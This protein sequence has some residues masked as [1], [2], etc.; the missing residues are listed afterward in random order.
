MSETFV[1]EQGLVQS[2]WVSV[3]AAVAL[4]L[5]GGIAALVPFAV[6]VAVGI[7]VVWVVVFSG[8][9]HLV[10]AWD[11][12][13]GVFVWRLLVGVV[14]LLGGLYL[15]INPVFDLPELARFIGGVFTV[16]SML[17]LAGAWLLRDR[18]GSGW[19]A[20]DAALTLLFAAGILAM[21][22]WARPWAVGLLVG[23]N[24]ISS[25]AV[26]LA[27]IHANGGSIRRMP[28]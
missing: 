23:L 26:F 12:R 24:V 8:L 5:L 9:A 13:G 18:R 20:L 4:L 15:L 25:G 2:T 1:P 17:L 16:E 6:G 14:Y 10:H 27:M 22:P 7:L 11:A 28:A 21:G 3:G 19:M